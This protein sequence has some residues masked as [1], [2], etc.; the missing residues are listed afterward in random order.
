MR[1]TPHGL[2]PTLALRYT[3]SMQYLTKLHALT[4]VKAGM[5]F[6]RLAVLGCIRKERD[7][8]GRSMLVWHCRCD[9]G[10]E[11]ETR[12]SNLLSGDTN[13]CGCY[14]RDLCI[15]RAVHG[16]ARDGR[17][18]PELLSWKN[19]HDRCT[20]PKTDAYPWYGGRGIKVCAR[21]NTF[22]SFLADVGPR[23]SRDYTLERLNTN[24]NYEPDNVV[25]ATRMQQGANKRNNRLLTVFGETL[26]MQEWCRRYGIKQGTLWDRLD[27]GWDEERAITTPVIS[28]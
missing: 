10:K 18:S 20:N 23:P 9:C 15:G 26:H 24:G 25:W 19:M 11:I 14:V 8:S 4:K 16:H 22:A 28:T 3:A 5:R 12:S 6:T 27:R 1:S 17:R 7:I 13:S 2:V 21:W